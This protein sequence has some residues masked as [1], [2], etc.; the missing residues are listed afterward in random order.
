MTPD[1]CALFEAAPGSYLAL[2]PDL[3]IVAVSD[4]YLRATMTKR[5]DILGRGLF[6][7]FPDNPDDPAATG[8][9]NLRASLDRVLRRRE[10]D[11]MAVQKYDIRRP[12]AEGGF[13][14]RHWSPVN[15]PV[16][17][18]DGTVAYIIHR[19]ED[20]TEFIRLRHQRSEQSKLTAELQARADKMEAEVYLRAQELQE[21]NKRLRAAQDELESRVRERTAEAAKLQEQL[22][23]SQKMESV[24]RLAGGIS[25]D[26]NNILTAIGGFS[27]F[28]LQSIP[29]G[30]P[31]RDDVQEIVA[32]AERAAALT[33]RLLAFS[34]RQILE[35]RLI[36]LNAVVASLQPMLKRLIGEHIELRS[37][38][39][40]G[41]GRV[42]ADPGQI[43]QVIMNL[44]VNARDA[45][46]KG[47]N[48]AIETVDASLGEDYARLHL[49][50]RPGPYVMLS[51]SDTGH[52]MSAAVQSRLF[53]PFFTTKEPGKGTGLGLATVYGIV[54]QSGGNIYVYSEPGQGCTFKIYLPRVENLETAPPPPP[55]PPPPLRGRET[56]LLVEDDDSV[57][58]FARRTLIESG[59]QVLDARGAEEALTAVERHSGNIHLILTDVVMPRLRGPEL[60]KLLASRRPGVKV[61]FMSGYTD[62]DM[63]E[64]DVLGPKAAYLQKPL[65]PGSLA[66]KV[67]EVLDQT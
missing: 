48:I 22:L 24:G 44:V 32:A 33:R 66:D 54:K 50:V 15:T 53:E 6:E 36:D 14:V 13:E 30:D 40:R 16:L 43:E 63:L 52:G 10:P 60:F 41:I 5:A 1:Y 34:R 64:R 42:K 26:F 55:T 39:A 17:A 57:R 25:H 21:A 51:V 49:E 31:R 8:T 2:T 58:K 19:V 4:D 45:L 61:I 37:T 3:N 59:Y 12:D 28:L 23:L 20:V 27:G 18:A 9:R 62:Q 29:V 38:L 46:P 47:G 56:V 7:V 35:P 65:T 11:T 67:R